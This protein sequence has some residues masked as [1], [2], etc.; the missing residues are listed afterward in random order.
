MW[1]QSKSLSLSH[2]TK[3]QLWQW[4]SRCVQDRQA[5]KPRAHHFEMIPCPPTI[6][7]HGQQVC[8]PSHFHRWTQQT[9]SCQ[10]LGP[11]SSCLH[12]FPV[13][14][15][16][17]LFFED[18]QIS[19][20]T[21][22]L[23]VCEIWSEVVC[24]FCLQLQKQDAV[25]TW[26]VAWLSIWARPSSGCR[27]FQSEFPPFGPVGIFEATIYPPSRDTSNKHLYTDISATI[28]GTQGGDLLSYGQ[29]AFLSSPAG[30][31]ST[32]WG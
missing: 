1:L 15:S 4:D 17:P 3:K 23:S 7:R 2:F 29:L 28:L 32:S 14:I 18:Y 20:E 10:L 24:I 27:T 12:A 8:F 5:C 21:K 31:W 26:S 9:K 22:N 19:F 11:I 16:W 6:L 30:I 25:F 13:S